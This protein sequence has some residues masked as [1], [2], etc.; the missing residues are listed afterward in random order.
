MNQVIEFETTRKDLSH[1]TGLT[2]FTNLINRLN[3]EGALGKILPQM[4]HK[5]I[6]KTKEKFIAG[7]LG[8]IAGAD[9]IDDLDSLKQ[10]PL[11]SS[12]THGGIAPST[13]R[14]FMGR[15]E[16]KHFERLQDLLP[17]VA[18]QLRTMLLGNSSTITITMDATPHE[19]HGEYMEGVDWCYNKKK[20]YITQNAFDDKGFCYG[21]NLMSGNSHSHNGAVEMIERVFKH[22]PKN[23]KRYFRADSAYGSHKVYNSL[24]NLGVHFGICLSENVWGALLD[25]NEFK[26]KWSKT[27][28]R[29][30]DSNKCQ[31]ASTIYSPKNLKGRS[32]LRV[33]YIRAPKEV[34]TKEDKRHYRYYA[35][36]TDLPESEMSNEEVIQF[37]RGRANAENHIKDLKNGMDFKHFPCQSMNKNKA[38]G[39]MGIYAY[40][41]MRYASFAI[42]PQGCFLKRVR[43]KLVYIAA[44]LRRGQKKI[45]LRVTTHIYQE[46][47]RLKE[48]LHSKHC[49]HGLYRLSR[50]SSRST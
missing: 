14:K 33:V 21:W 28:I 8:F 32:F 26:M 44:E 17:Q 11:F 29:F 47:T 18:Y 6:L 2:F 42:S 23:L 41:L 40:N 38:C 50:G 16:L 22:I 9:C 35:I 49:T 34:I 7:M 43:T 31:I 1:L 19:Q 24:I 3:L 12:L 5:A 10:D 48:K 20:G 30:F 45:K 36:I 13:M 4:G 39:F 27:R 25:R 15:F 46:V 37:Y